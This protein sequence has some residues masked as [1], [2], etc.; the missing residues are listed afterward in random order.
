MI[1]ADIVSALQAL[2]D[3]LSTYLGLRFAF[4]QAV[5][6]RAFSPQGKRSGQDLRDLTITLARP[7]GIRCARV[8]LHDSSLSLTYPSRGKRTP[9]PEKIDLGGVSKDSADP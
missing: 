7:A 5:K 2:R 6:G 3:V 1:L 9:L 8:R 4:A